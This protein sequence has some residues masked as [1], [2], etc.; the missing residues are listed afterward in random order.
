MSMDTDTLKKI[1][2]KAAELGVNLASRAAT[3]RAYNAG[4][5]TAQAARLGQ[6]AYS[7]EKQVNA[8]LLEF[9]DSVS[10]AS[11]PSWV[12]LYNSATR[13]AQGDKP[14]DKAYSDWKGITGPGAV[15]RELAQRQRLRY[16]NGYPS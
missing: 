10:C 15:L 12:L 3:F 9:M 5:L 14:L 1:F 7:Y 16:P 11:L 13:P 8:D 6:F 4:V 2:I